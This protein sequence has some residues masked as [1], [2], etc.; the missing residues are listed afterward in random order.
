MAKQPFFMRLTPEEYVRVNS[1][2]NQAFL[3]RGLRARRRIQAILLSHKG[4]TVQRIAY[5][6]SVSQ[7]IIWKWF[8]LYQEKGLEGLRGKYFSHKL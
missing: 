1:Y 5:N 6:L 4:W 8:K 3:E 7:R 2:L